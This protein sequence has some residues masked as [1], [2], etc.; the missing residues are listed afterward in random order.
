MNTIF[1]SRDLPKHIMHVHQTVVVS[2]T[3]SYYDSAVIILKREA[4]ARLA[5]HIVEGNRGFR[6]RAD[7]RDGNKYIDVSID[8]IVLTAEEYL[9]LKRSSFKE[10]MDYACGFV[11]PRRRLDEDV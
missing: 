6:I 1:D 3:S 8:C 4:A 2:N 7:E 9:Q 11:P 5:N 10:G